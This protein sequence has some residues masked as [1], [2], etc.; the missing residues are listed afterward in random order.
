[1]KYTQKPLIYLASPYSHDDPI[2]VNQRERAIREVV[3]EIIGK[4]DA[5]I[6]FSPIIYT[7]PIAKNV[8]P[9]FDWYP[10]DLQF[11]SRCDAMI[12]V[13]L[14]GWS[15]SKGIQ[16]EIQHCRDRDIPIAFA[17]P[18]NILEVCDSISTD[19]EIAH[20]AAALQPDIVIETEHADGNRSVTLTNIKP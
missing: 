19:L 15:A 11:L 9:D 18:E 4:Q 6:P 13:Q 17:L 20:F 10:W 5:I 8:N 1:M 7:H 3:A 14:Q 16:I 2:V 12:V